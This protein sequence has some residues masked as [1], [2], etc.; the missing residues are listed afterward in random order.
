M[1]KEISKANKFMLTLAVAALVPGGAMAAGDVKGVN[2][3][4]NNHAVQSAQQITSTSQY[5]LTGF[6]KDDNG[7]PLI[8][9]SVKGE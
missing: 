2:A 4:M 8:G 9:V 3:V 5:V 7:E 1:A 6:V